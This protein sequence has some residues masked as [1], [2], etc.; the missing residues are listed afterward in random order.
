MCSPTAV[1]LH[2]E[3]ADVLP[4]L[5]CS[6]GWQSPFLPGAWLSKG[7]IVSVLTVMKPYLLGTEM[8]FFLC[9]LFFFFFFLRF[10]N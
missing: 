9:C 8:L 7:G 1:C 10:S 5:R 2:Q 4:E 6:W 3:D